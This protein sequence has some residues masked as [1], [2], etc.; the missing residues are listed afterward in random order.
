MNPWRC[1]RRTAGLFLAALLLA[2]AGF[3]CNDG[4]TGSGDR[5]TLPWPDQLQ[6]TPAVE[7]RQQVRLDGRYVKEVRLEPSQT[8]GLAPQQE[9][10]VRFLATGMSQVKQ[11]EFVVRVEPSGAFDLSA[12]TFAPAKPFAT[13]GNGVEMVEEGRLRIAGALFSRDQTVQ[14]DQLLGALSLKTSPAY[15]P[16]A[17]PRVRVEF[18]SVGPTSTE[19]DSYTEEQLQ[20]GVALE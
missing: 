7:L 14:G 16:S 9:V 17:Q 15:S 1:A 13:F 20:L 18:F 5:P 8:R 4:R 12:A 10:T 3:H 11:F 2:V 6:S 19:R